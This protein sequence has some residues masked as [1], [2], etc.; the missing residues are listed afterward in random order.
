MGIGFDEFVGSVFVGLD[1]D[2]LGI[3]QCLINPL[4]RIG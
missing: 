4:K 3:A 1:P 2:F